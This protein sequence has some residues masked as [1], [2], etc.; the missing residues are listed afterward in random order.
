MKSIMAN[1]TIIQ[2]GL[3][4]LLIMRQINGKKN[5]GKIR[6]EKYFFLLIA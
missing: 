5:G 6:E 2:C 1:E 4:N 3:R